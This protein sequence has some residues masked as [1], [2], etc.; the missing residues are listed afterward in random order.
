QARAVKEEQDRFVT[1]G[2]PGLRGILAGFLGQRH[3]LVGRDRPRH[4]AWLFRPL[5]PRQRGVAALLLRGK[6]EKAADRRKLARRRGI[7]E[8]G[9]PPPG[10]VSAQIR[11]LQT[12]Q[13]RPVDR[14]AE[15][16]GEEGDQPVRGGEIGAD[17]ML[18]TA[19]LT[20]EM[21]VPALGDE[22]RRM[23]RRG[24]GVWGIS[25]RPMQRVS[26][27]PRKMRS[28]DPWRVSKCWAPRWPSAST[29]FGSGGSLASRVS[30]PA[31]I[32]PQAGADNG[33]AGAA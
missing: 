33:W 15:M 19:P 17:R 24:A 20:G 14:P 22:P 2:D 8:P 23:G 6:G 3:R 29:P 10:E 11:R 32:K 1:G 30:A 16:V 27:R 7:A 4:A 9:R 21:V 26:T 13:G 31:R 18:R 25:P 12:K 28:S 5:E